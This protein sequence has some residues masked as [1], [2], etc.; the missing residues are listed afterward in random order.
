M[1]RNRFIE[2]ILP[3]APFSPFSD[4]PYLLPNYLLCLLKCSS[5]IVLLTV[6][7]PLTVYDRDMIA[8]ND[9]KTK[10]PETYK[11]IHQ[12]PVICNLTVSSLENNPRTL[13]CNTVPAGNISN[14]IARYYISIL[15]GIS[16]EFEMNK[17][18]GNY[19]KMYERRITWM[20]NID[21]L[22]YMLL[23]IFW[24]VTYLEWD[25]INS[26][27]NKIN[28]NSSKLN[29]WIKKG[30][31]RLAWVTSGSDLEKGFPGP[32]RVLI[33]KMGNMYD[34]KISTQKQKKHL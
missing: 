3:L 32:L 29:W 18:Q 4:N 5:R 20:K 1:F 33:K 23:F 30:L 12:I 17:N 2:D 15:D 16:G 7:F 31:E 26:S 22:W 19:V 11:A 9:N 27:D 21:F 10:S 28:N 24:F 14:H 25:K 13:L 6:Q 34:S 8:V